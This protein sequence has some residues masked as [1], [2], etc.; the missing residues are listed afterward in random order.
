LVERKRS[1]AVSIE[2][3][4][5]QVAKD[6]PDDFEV[7]FLSVP[8]GTGVV[9]IIKN[10]LFFRP[11]AADIYH[12]TGDVHYISLVL[13]R[14][15]SVLTV[16]DLVF[17]HRRT[18]LRRFILKKLY[19]DFPLRRLQH[20]T[21]ISRAIKDEIIE[22]T[23]INERRLTIIENPLLEGFV[24]DGER[25]FDDSCPTILHIGTAENK[26]LGNLIKAVE[27]INC[28]LRIIGKL[29]DKIL[30]ILSD[31]G[32]TYESENALDDKKIIDEYRNADIVSL[33]STYEG[34]GLPIIEAQA[35][36]K[37]VITSNLPPMKDVAGKGAELVDPHDVRSIRA[38]LMR[39][40][41]DLGHRNMLIDAGFENVKRFD[42]R[43][44]AARYADVYRQIVKST[45]N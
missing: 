18:G 9:A 1:E 43:L 42:R 14:S 31:T 12:I 20:F 15:R 26:N 40:I 3:V 38:G 21:V 34:F 23:G 37:P 17:L 33:C 22:Q 41:D 11:P 8:F 13:P 25:P 6:L 30:R 10:L 29:D 45:E 39:L 27:G 44:A 19:L 4:F 28:K 35:L 32:A 7:E 5:R 2:R 36:K 24:A 16:H